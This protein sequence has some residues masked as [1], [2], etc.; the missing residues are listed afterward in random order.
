MFLQSAPVQSQPSTLNASE[1][2]SGAN[3]D[4]IVDIIVA[5]V[6]QLVEATKVL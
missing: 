2:K 1:I 6:I 4:R 3:K 5:Q